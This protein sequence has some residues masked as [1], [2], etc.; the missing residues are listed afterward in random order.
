MQYKHVPSREFMGVEIVG[1]VFVTLSALLVLAM[2]PLHAAADTGP[3]VEGV[4]RA[5][6]GSPLPH[7]QVVAL[8]TGRGTVT[9]RA[10]RFVLR[11]LAPGRYR[12][13]VTAIGYRPVV[14]EVEV[15]AGGGPVRLAVTLTPTPL[16]IPGV[17]VTA[18]PGGR[19]ALGV[20]QATTQLSGRQLERSLGGTVAQTLERQPGIGVRYNGPATA[21]PVMRGLTGDRIL[22][23]QDGQ[24]VADLSGSADDHSVTVDPLA[25]QRIEVVR[26]PASLLYGTNALG[27]VVNVISGDLAAGSPSRAQ[28]SVAL[29]SESA[30]PGGAGSLRGLVPLGDRWALSARGGG[31]STGDA[32]IGGDPVLGGR[33]DNTFH[34]NASGA[35]GLAYFGSRV[36]GGLSMQGYGMEHGV[37]LPPEEDDV[38]VLRGRKWTGAG[39][40]EIGLGGRF[41]PSLRLQGSATD[42]A[43]DEWEDDEL[44]MAFG[45]RTQTVDLLLRQG[46]VGRL[47]EGA[48][49]ASGLFRQ[50]AATGEEQLT[51]P[52]DSRSFGVFTFQEL[53]LGGGGAALQLGARVDRYAI[54]SR[55]DPGFGSGVERNFTAL[56]GSA[57]A[58]LPLAPGASLGVSAARSFRAPT[59]EELFSDALHLGTASYEIGDAD[60]RPEVSQGL[61]A[62]LRIARA[63]LS[64]EVSAY[65]NEVRDFIFFE[66]RGDTVIDGSTWPVLA[67]VQ[68]G[69]RFAGL[70]GRVEWEAVPRWV[71]ALQGDLVRATLRE[72]GAVPFLP[73]ARIG[74]SLRHEA[75]P[76][77]AGVGVRHA[78]RQEGAPLADEVATDAYT[79][80]DADVGLRL[81]RGGQVHSLTLRADNL[82][83]ALYFDAASRIKEFAP[84][85]GRNLSLLYRVFF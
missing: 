22:I 28:W 12:L 73:P 57:G 44:E 76:W 67:Y 39:N 7:A 70:E 65:G 31:R 69:A 81:V 63:R 38:I 84:N 51:A 68:D 41:F 19:D 9:D 85:P 17:Q 29:Q 21:A 8:P 79:L 82:A 66:Q 74:G 34:R 32:R 52:A 10:G 3:P 33:L 60:L 6:D 23:L 72:G 37:P 36:S 49:G 24:R 45:L 27:G 35:L 16:S 75:G 83:D 78:F 55:D 56:S 1:R 25:A 53:P 2:P 18:T 20:A 71:V 40:L 4:V 58:T 14:E 80:L 11:D 62:V 5:G 47:G 43:H 54:V 50:Y 64:A 26:G 30:F 59:V 13:E 61:D 48:W 77:S 15:R 46:A 42:Y